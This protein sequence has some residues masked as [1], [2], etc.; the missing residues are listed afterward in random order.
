[1]TSLAPAQIPSTALP[2]TNGTLEQLALWALLA[3][4]AANG[5]KGAVEV[6]GSE[7]TDLVQF[8]VFQ[9]PDGSYRALGRVNIEL[10][11]TYLTD[12]TNPF[13]T[14]AQELTT[15]ALPPNYA[16]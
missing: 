6:S 12:D 13:W 14:F 2:A 10:D 11:P 8:Q 3:L 15:G 4:K 9:Q 1:M 16:A 5:T 7:A